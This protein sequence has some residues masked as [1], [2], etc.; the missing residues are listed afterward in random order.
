M[1]KVI[2]TLLS[3]VI[4]ICKNS[5]IET[6]IVIERIQAASS[7]DGTNP[8][9]VFIPG[10]LWKPETSLDGITI[11]FS[12]GAKWNQA[13]KTDGRAYF[14]EISIECQE[15]KGYVSLYK[16]GSYATNFDCSK[17][18]PL[19][20]K[21]N[22]IHVIYLLPDGANGIKTVSFFKNGKKLDVVY[23]EPIEGQVTAS[24]TLPNYPAYG[25]FDGSIDFAW[26]EG[27]KTDGVGE[28]FQVELEKQIDL[29]GIEIFN[30]YQRLDA[31]FYKN[32]SVTELLVSNG[33]DSFTLPI[34]DKQGGQR[35]FFPKILSGKTFTFTIQKVRTG[36]TWKDTVIAEI[37][38]LGENGKRFTV[39]DQNANQ[40]KDEILKKSKNTIL[41]GIVNKAYF[42]DI[43][44]GRMDY[45]F[46]SNGSFVIWLDDL[47][48]KRVLDGNWVFLEANATE[49]KIKIFGRDHKVVTQSLDVNSPYSETTEEKST[50]IFGD[51]LLVKKSGNGIQ[52]V[53][54]KVQISN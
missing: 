29:A 53:G 54:K 43:P 37:I 31:L 28:S 9:N 35:I 21:S 52:M 5:P 2:F 20:I 7:A 3:F 17:E 32:G 10:K 8:I 15:K 47:K 41:A 30:G 40:F 44:E 45:V 51:T 42:A 33:T 16:D 1:K 19:K 6:S 23:P 27:V 12:N 18:T 13:G 46:R 36:K 50:V 39:M 22:G 25:M 34:A 38:F 14:N 48:E 24:S 26:V 11:F 4:L 49:A